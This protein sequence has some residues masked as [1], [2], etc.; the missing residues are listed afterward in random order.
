MCLCNCGFSKCSCFFCTFSSFSVPLT[1]G[2]VLPSALIMLRLQF[3]STGTK[4]IDNRILFGRI[5]N[6]FVIALPVMEPNYTYVHIL[7]VSYR[8]KM[9]TTSIHYYYCMGKKYS[10]VTWPWLTESLTIFR[11][12]A[13]WLT[14]RRRTKVNSW[15]NGFEFNARKSDHF[16]MGLAWWGGPKI[17]C[18][19]CNWKSLKSRL[20]IT[21]SPPILYQLPRLTL[22]PRLCVWVFCTHN[23]LRYS[24]LS[25]EWI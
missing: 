14:V 3:S 7:R 18:R 2:F 9:T 1:P 16:S 23:V 8:Y 11:L 17:T 12:L 4:R 24:N 22:S 5:Q 20:S 15:M 13:D 21:N 19:R 10:R 25:A 6:E